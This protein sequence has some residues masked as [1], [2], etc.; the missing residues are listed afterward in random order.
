MLAHS[1]SSGEVSFLFL[2]QCP[3]PRRQ[4]HHHRWWDNYLIPI[5][6]FGLLLG[7]WARPVHPAAHTGLRGLALLPRS[8]SLGEFCLWMA[9][10]FVWS[11]F[12]CP[13]RSCVPAN[14]T[15]AKSGS[16]SPSL[17][18]SLFQVNSSS[19]MAGQGSHCSGEGH[20][21][22]NRCTSPRNKTA[23]ES[24]CLP[25]PRPFSWAH[26]GGSHRSGQNDSQIWN[27]KPCAMAGTEPSPAGPDRSAPEGDPAQLPASGQAW[28]SPREGAAFSRSWPSVSWSPGVRARGRHMRRLLASPRDGRLHEGLQLPRLTLSLKLKSP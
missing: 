19:G 9:G 18:T 11:S 22:E 4:Y 17:G 14:P 1:K 24:G 21:P 5:C 28:G 23:S 13:R 7:R 20:G 8:A 16:F 10:K 27:W 3:T 6:P 2:P 12:F 15:E 25:G 26:A